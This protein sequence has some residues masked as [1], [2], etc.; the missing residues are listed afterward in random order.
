MDADGDTDADSDADANGLLRGTVLVHIGPGATRHFTCF[1][2]VRV[3]LCKLND[4]FELGFG[5]S[6]S[7]LFQQ[8]P[9]FEIHRNKVVGIV[10]HTPFDDILVPFHCLFEVLEFM[11]RA[12]GKPHPRMGDELGLGMILDQ[13][14]VK[15]AGILP[16]L[17]SL[18]PVIGLR[19]FLIGV[20]S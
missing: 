14:A 17:S 19:R 8:A 12:F 16:M 5:L 9:R 10:G 13:L 15:R 1:G 11:K 3:L 4:A 6:L 20:M 2:I 18:F 7:A